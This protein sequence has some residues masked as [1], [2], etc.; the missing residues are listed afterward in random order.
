MLEQLYSYLSS[1]QGKNFLTSVLTILGIIAFCYK[2][3]RVWTLR[4]RD[5]T[6]RALRALYFYLWAGLT[7]L[8]TVLAGLAILVLVGILSLVIWFGAGAVGA[9]V[10]VLFASWAGVDDLQTAGDFGFAVVSSF[11]A[12]LLLLMGYVVIFVDPPEAD[13]AEDDPAPDAS[14]A[15]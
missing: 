8:P 2:T 14:P 4:G 13:A 9:I 5:P 10:A 3:Y 12:G 7:M 15:S 6:I 11:V 1:D